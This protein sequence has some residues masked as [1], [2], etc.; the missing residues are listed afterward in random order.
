M[1]SFNELKSVTAEMSYHVWDEESISEAD[2][3][4]VFFNSLSDSVKLNENKSIKIFMLLKCILN[5]SFDIKLIMKYFN[6]LILASKLH[7][8]FNDDD[9]V[10]SLTKCYMNVFD[11]RFAVFLN[12]L[13]YFLMTVLKF[14]MTFH[15]INLFMN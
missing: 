2:V 12:V 9:N 8:R 4:H 13:W 1:S 3:V 10:I 6:R 5:A 14:F 7:I 11:F 15:E